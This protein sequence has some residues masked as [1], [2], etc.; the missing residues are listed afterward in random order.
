MGGAGF[1]GEMGTGL[2][3]WAKLATTTI[4]CRRLGAMAILI[5]EAIFLW[6]IL[7]PAHASVPAGRSNSSGAAYQ[8]VTAA[9]SF[10]QSPLLDSDGRTFYPYS[11]IPGGARNAAELQSALAHDG[12]VAEHYSD[13]NLE[14]TRVTRLSEARALFVSYRVGNRI[15]WTKNRMT[16]PEG[17]TVLTDGAHM[18]RTRCGNRLSE[19]PGEP[20]LMAEPSPE[21]MELPAARGPLAMLVAPPEIPLVAPPTTGIVAPETP[22]GSIF[23]PPIVPIF[24]LGG[25]PFPP[26]GPT[27]P[28]P[29]T[30]PPSPPPSGPPPP[31]PPPPP[32]PPPVSAPEPSSVLT[33]TAGLVGL[34]IFRR[35][36]RA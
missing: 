18:A 15:F 24:P 34:W 19:V 1:K 11:V 7:A 32:P 25:G 9:D 29:P 5:L 21:A 23:I 27:T 20:V 28:T 3:S 30:G 16:L 6:A 35:K 12:V 36:N 4:D 17:E 14:K 8:S 31:A 26:G 2:T 13:F 33:L 10:P 22:P